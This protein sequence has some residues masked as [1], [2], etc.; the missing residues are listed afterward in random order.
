M[1]WVFLRNP[2]KSAGERGDVVL[3][4]TKLNY[5]LHVGLRRYSKDRSG[6]MVQ[7]VL[8]LAVPI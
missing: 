1:Q 4:P 6:E 8:M 2:T 7:W 5:C 3:V